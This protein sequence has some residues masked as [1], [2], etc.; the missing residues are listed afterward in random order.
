VG[1]FPMMDDETNVVEQ[2]DGYTSPLQ[3]YES[4]VPSWPTVARPTGPMWW[5]ST[6]PVEPTYVNDVQVTED[7]PG[8]IIATTDSGPAATIEVV[9]DD[10]ITVLE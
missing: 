2:N 4:F 6:D 7:Y 3:Q 1:N 9:G 5:D 10:V 8:G